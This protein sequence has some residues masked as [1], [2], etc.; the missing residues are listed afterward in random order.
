MTNDPGIKL[1]RRNALS[2][3]GLGAV[4][5]LAAGSAGAAV[6]QTNKVTIHHVEGRR[7]QR[8]IWF[9]E[10]AGIPYEVIYK[11]GDVLGS[12]NALK[13]VNPDMP[14]APTVTTT[15]VMPNIHGDSNT[16]NDGNSCVS[17]PNP[18]DTHEPILGRPGCWLPL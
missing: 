14:T 8:I 1:S 2:A 11:R 17:L 15:G 7:S 16:T 18:Y 10:E 9:C 12:L 3:A 6:R 13:V 5:T 4:G